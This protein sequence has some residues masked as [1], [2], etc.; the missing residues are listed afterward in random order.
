MLQSNAYDAEINAF[1]CNT[2]NAHARM[3]MVDEPQVFCEDEVLLLAIH[4][5]LLHDEVF[6]HRILL[7]RKFKSII[8]TNA[9]NN[10]KA[11]LHS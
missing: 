3:W 2:F 1:R 7:I 9:Y 10:W 6:R 8:L 4:F 11:V 5:T